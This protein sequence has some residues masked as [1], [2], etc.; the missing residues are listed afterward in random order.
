MAP[1]AREQ[2]NTRQRSA[3]RRS[4]EVSKRPLSAQQVLHAAK[5]E[6]RGLGIATVYRN[7][8]CLLND[9]W[10]TALEVPGAG[11]VYELAGKPHHHHFHCERCSHVFE[12]SG[13]V[14]KIDH[15]ARRGFFVTRHELVL[16]GL[17]S[18]CRGAVR[19]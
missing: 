18:D 7:I 2:R 14:P 12:V 4:F 11:T 13:C 8:Q 17:C 16:Y 5:A 9:G 1:K 10:L 6:V 3:I 15:L 19:S